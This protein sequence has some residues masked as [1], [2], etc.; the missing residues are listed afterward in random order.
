M[1]LKDRVKTVKLYLGLLIYES[2]KLIC[3]N[4]GYGYL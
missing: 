4:K 2:L 1:T 3:Q